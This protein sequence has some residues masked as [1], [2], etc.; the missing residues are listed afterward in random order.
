MVSMMNERLVL[1]ERL[2]TWSHAL[3]IGLGLLAVALLGWLGVRSDD[4]WTLAS[5]LVYAFCMGFSYV[6]STLYHACREPSRKS[7]LRKWDHAA[8]Y[9][10]IAGTYTPFTLM[11]LRGQGFWG[12]G[13]FLFIWLAALVGVGLTFRHMRKEDHLKTACYLMMGWA[14][15]VAFKPLLDA[16]QAQGRMESLYWLLG[17]GLSYTFGTLFFFLDNGRRNYV[18]FIWHLFVLG[19]SVCHFWS[20]CLLRL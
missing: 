19:G 2:N 11:V 16:C 9:L 20:I 7:R 12:W 15:I 17:G 13:L 5:F 18:H 3:G 10:H 4:P 1:D 6:V 8:I 14:I